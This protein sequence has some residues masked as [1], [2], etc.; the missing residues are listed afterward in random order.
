MAENPTAWDFIRSAW[1]WFKRNYGNIMLT[2][3]FLVLF[4]IY[5]QLSAQWDFLYNIDNNIQQIMR[6][7]IDESGTG[8]II[9]DQ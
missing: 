9:Y 2:L 6:Y 5:G 3:I 7:G 8:A 4:Y 1:A